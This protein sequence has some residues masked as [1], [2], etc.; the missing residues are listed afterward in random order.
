M[1]FETPS[2]EGEWFPETM[3]ETSA[4]LDVLVRGLLEKFPSLSR[5]QLEAMIKSP[6]A[7]AYLKENM[8]RQL[9]LA[10]V[11]GSDLLDRFLTRK[12]SGPEMSRELAK[13][14]AKPRILIAHYLEGNVAAQKFFENLAAAER[15]LHKELNLTRDRLKDHVQLLLGLGKD[16]L[17]E[18]RQRVRTFSLSF[19]APY[20]GVEKLPINLQEALGQD[21]FLEELPA[22]STHLNLLTAY[23]RDIIYPSKVMPEIKESDA[24]DILHATYLPYVELYR[25]DSRFGGLLVKLQKPSS[26]KVVPNLL[27][28]PEAIE[29]ELMTRIS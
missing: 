18:V 2:N 7:M 19:S 28:L 26:V 25:T 6:Q 24:A 1:T 9:P 8:S 11:Y 3:T 12:I 16:I 29:K 15:E 13:G 5:T 27:Q 20:L 14:F 22:L 10:N 4:D 23:L 17:K 21:G